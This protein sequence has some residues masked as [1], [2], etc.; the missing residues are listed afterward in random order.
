PSRPV[1]GWSVSVRFL[2]FLLV[3][4]L[5][6]ARGA[7]SGTGIFATPIMA[8]NLDRGALTEW[9]DGSTRPLELKG[10]P[11]DVLW[12]RDSRIEWAGVSFGASKKAGARH[13][14]LGWRTA[15]PIG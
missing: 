5:Q 3:F 14:R 4:I 11:R 9:V 8:T 15:L 12:T 6:V 10:G 13:L 1:W 7:E 2:G